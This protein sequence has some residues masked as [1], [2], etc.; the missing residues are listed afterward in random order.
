M[1]AGSTAATSFVAPERPDR[2]LLTY[3]LLAAL[4][5]G[6]F[7]PIV[8][9]VMYFRYHT[10]RYRFTAEGLSMSWGLLFR[11]EVIIQFA[12]IQD[13][14]LRSNA[15]E[16]HL[17]LGRILIQ[18]ASGNAGAEMTLE[19]LKNFEEVRDHLYGRM[20]GVHDQAPAQAAVG[21]GSAGG[22]AASAEIAAALREAAAALRAVH[23][24]LTER[25]HRP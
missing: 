3:Y 4:L 12:R 6:P 24:L 10:M 16:R 19:G 7:F 15:V 2:A 25:G 13:I 23:E 8:A 14:H 5:A 1:A 9:T 21:A 20:R 22:D 11:R 17:G 18:T